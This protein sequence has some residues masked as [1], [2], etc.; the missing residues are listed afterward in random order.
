MACRGVVV[1]VLRRM[2]VGEALPFSSPYPSVVDE[3]LA[4]CGSIT[5]VGAVGWGGSVT[6]LLSG[7]GG[8]DSFRGGVESQLQQRAAC[9]GG[10]PHAVYAAA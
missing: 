5:G 3:G 4:H 1:D 6:A 7:R 8:V 2:H 9:R 10:V